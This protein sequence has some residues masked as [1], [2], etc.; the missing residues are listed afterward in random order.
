MNTLKFCENNLQDDMKDLVEKAKAEFTNVD[1][2]IEPCLG[3]CDTCAATHFA[4]ANDDVVE[5]DTTHLL[6]ERIKNK[7]GEQ[8]VAGPKH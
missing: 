7:I 8:E 4:L 1:I 6:F 2:A 5:G 3:R